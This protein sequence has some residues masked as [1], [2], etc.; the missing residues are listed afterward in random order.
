MVLTRKRKNYSSDDVNDKHRP[1]NNLNGLSIRPRVNYINYAEREES[2][3]SEKEDSYEDKNE[4][5]E[6]EEE[7]EEYD[8]KKY[9]NIVKLKLPFHRMLDENNYDKSDAQEDSKEKKDVNSD[10]SINKNGYWNFVSKRPAEKLNQDLYKT[11]SVRQILLEEKKNPS[12][13]SKNKLTDSSSEYE[14]GSDDCFSDDDSKSLSSINETSDFITDDSYNSYRRTKR[15]SRNTRRGVER[16]SRKSKR[17]SSFDEDGLEYDDDIEEDEII[18]ELRDLRSP[19][20]HRVNLRQ[21]VSRP[22]YTIPPPLPTQLPTPKKQNM[23]GRITSYKLFSRLGRTS[24]LHTTT[25][26]TISG[27]LG[28]LKDIAESSNSEDELNRVRKFELLGSKSFLSTACNTDLAGVPNDFGR[29]K[30]DLADTDPLGVNQAATFESIGGL[31]DFIIQL[32]EMVSLPLLY[33]EIF[34]RFNITPPKGVLFHGPPGTGK[35]LMARALATS[36]SNK[37][38]KISFFMRKGADCLS[39]WVGE[40]ERQL[41]LLFE[42]AKNSQPSIIFFDEIDGLAPVR[43]SKQE[44]IHASIV[45]TLLALMDGMDSRGQIVV[46]GATNRPD[47]VDPA[48]RRPGRFDREFYF[49]L[50]DFEARLSIIKIYTKGWDPPLSESFQ[51]QLAEQTKGYGGADLKALCTEA[52][53]SAVQRQYPQIYKNS[54]KLLIDSENIKVGPKDFMTS[55]K[56]IIPSSQRC[57]HLEAS[58]L[59]DLVTPLLNSK[60]L[61]IKEKLSYI[62]PQNKKANSLEK[63][64]CKPLEE[65]S[66]E[67]ENFLETFEMSRIFRPRLLIHGKPGMGQQYIG[68]AV[69]YHFEGIYVR[70]FDLASLMEDSTKTPESLIVQYFI[71]VKRHKPSVI[72]IPDFQIWYYAVSESVKTTLRMLLTSLKSTEQI[73][74]FVVVNDVIGKLDKEA[75]LWLNISEENMVELVAPIKD[76][77]HNFFK[78]LIDLIEISPSKI[79]DDLKRKKRILEDLPK[80]PSPP[81]RVLTKNELKELEY[82]DRKL[83]NIVKVKL[84]PLM[85]MLKTRYKRFR[86]PIID[87]NEIWYLMTSPK[88]LSIDITDQ[89][90]ELVENNLIHEKATGKKFINMD[91]ELIEEKLWNSIYLSPKQ[92]LHDIKA[93]MYDANISGDRERLLKA[94]EMYTNAQMSVED[95]SD[96]YFILECRRMIE[97]EKERQKNKILEIDKNNMLE[98]ENSSNVEKLDENNLVSNA[99]ST[100]ELSLENTKANDV[101]TDDDMSYDDN[102]EHMIDFAQIDEIDYKNNESNMNIDFENNKKMDTNSSKKST[103]KDLDHKPGDLAFNISSSLK[104]DPTSIN[105]VNEKITNVSQLLQID[106]DCDSNNEIFNIEN[107]NDKSVFTLILDVSKLSFLLNKMVEMTDRASVEDLEKLYSV[108]INILWQQKNNWNKNDVIDLIEQVFEKTWEDIKRLNF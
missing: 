53:L 35:T 70:S 37:E 10:K 95:I 13:S 97:R 60:L 87:P 44:Q 24:N 81:P 82:R 100:T 50:P 15:K 77:R 1:N 61:E 33:P 2:V 78:K 104:E 108:C 73:L 67:Y 43:S 59:P 49:S 41:R 99:P 39:K 47:A 25:I 68:A 101:I 84:S 91:L 22:D 14:Y 74:F 17:N 90:Y 38:R 3:I 106:P 28:I 71:E 30:Q 63:A 16:S 102:I 32:K 103:L 88:D 23:N 36:C 85:E 31:N 62:M 45:S 21:R 83:K 75:L 66:F 54:D 11:R 98:V 58:S 107:I 48:L 40:A 105:D 27:D 8:E 65:N 96:S 57:T 5:E 93:I 72:Y 12:K 34:Q 42:E 26:P 19:S 18:K 9:S 80:A 69:L 79:P 56:K 76:S 86:K 51:K 46:I 92:F 20:P 4:E 7:E 94:Q 29:I 6:E 64:I 52:A 55:M 89:P